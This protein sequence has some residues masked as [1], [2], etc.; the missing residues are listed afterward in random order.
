[1]EHH[2][3]VRVVLVGLLCVG[4][5]CEA[6]PPDG[7]AVFESS[8][9]RGAV[10]LRSDHSGLN[11]GFEWARRT[12]MAYVRSGDPVGPWFEAAL[13]G[14]DAFCMRDVSHQAEGA[15]ALGL[16]EELLN[17]MRKFAASIS[18]SRDWCGFWEIDRLDRPAP[19]DYRSDDDF[20]YNLPANFDVVQAGLRAWEWTGD[21]TWLTDP[22]LETFRRRTLIDYVERQKRIP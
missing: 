10:E 19:V 12:A 20:W 5:A 3:K 16:S 9:T 17:M 8:P 15:L 22:L 2:R 13:P 6:G 18:D 4:T 14:R 11:E 21:T 7:R 1:M